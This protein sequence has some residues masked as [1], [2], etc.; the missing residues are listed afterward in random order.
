MKIKKFQVIRVDPD[1][2][3]V[4]LATLTSRP[5]ALDFMHTYINTN[6][7]IDNV[8]RKAQES[9][10]LKMSIYRYNWVMPKILEAQFSVNE[11]VDE[12]VCVDCVHIE[13]HE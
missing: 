12:C 8:T 11:Y 7:V 3:C 4:V 13:N 2:T 6:F 5:N 9:G 1:Y 10:Y